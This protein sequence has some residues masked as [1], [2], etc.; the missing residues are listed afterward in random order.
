MFKSLLIGFMLVI[1][2]PTYSQMLTEDQVEMCYSI[3]LLSAKV[4][5]IRSQDAP[6]EVVLELVATD[7]KKLS[8]LLISIVDMI[9]N[10]EISSVEEAGAVGAEMNEMCLSAYSNKKIDI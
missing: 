6:K 8:E 1:S 7:N 2:A 5:Y 9:Y 3:G 10:I 4:A